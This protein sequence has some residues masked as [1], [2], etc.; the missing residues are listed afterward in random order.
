V[1][2]CLNVSD[3]AI[4]EH[5]ALLAGGGG[6]AGRLNTDEER[7]ASLQAALQCGTH[8]GSCLPEL[9]R[10]VRPARGEPQ[11]PTQRTVDPNPAA[12]LSS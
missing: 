6:G 1:C 12:R 5:L 4:D 9:K 3:T 7:L 10:R 8:C 2:S 11:A